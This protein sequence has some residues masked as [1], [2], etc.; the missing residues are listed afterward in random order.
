MNSSWHT[1]SLNKCCFKAEAIGQK[2]EE[3]KEVITPNGTGGH[4]AREAEE[5]GLSHSLMDR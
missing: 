1:V 4:L 5:E 3:T 2:Q